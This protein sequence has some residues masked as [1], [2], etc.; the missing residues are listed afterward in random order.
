MSTMSS[1][2]PVPGQDLPEQNGGSRANHQG[3][4]PHRLARW[5]RGFERP[6]LARFL[7]CVRPY[8]RYVVGAALAGIG[9]FALPFAF[10]LAFKYVLDVL[11]VPQPRPGALDG[12]IDRWCTEV[13]SLLGLGLTPRGKLIALTV[14]MLGLYAIQSVASYY[15]NYWAGVAGNGLIF[16]LRCR[17]FAHLQRLP[18]SFFDRNPPGAVVSRMVNDVE[19]ARQFVGSTMTDVWMDGVALLLIGWFLFLLDARLAIISLAVAPLYVVMITYFSPRIRRA[20]R[21]IQETLEDISASLHERVVGAVTVKAFARESHEIALF[22][23]QA[24]RLYDY[25]IDKLRLTSGQQMLTELLTRV[26][27]S[28]VVWAAA[29][30]I[31]GHTMT[32]GTLVAFIGFLGYIYQPLEHFTQLSSVVSSALSAIERIF[33]LLDVAPDIRDHPLAR[34]LTVRRGALEFEDV[35]FAYPSRQ[36]HAERIV[37]GDISF[38][39]AGG[40]T[41]ALVGR[42]GAGKTTLAS[43]IPRFYDAT[44]GRVLIDGKDVRHLTLKSLRENIG[45]VTQ[46]TILFSA[47]VRDNLLYGNPRADEQ[48]LWDALA[49]A[50]LKSFVESLPRGL[51]TVIGERG[52][53]IS[54]GQRQRLALARAF[55]KNPAIL[56]LDE[57]TSAVDSESENLIHD[58]MHR[59]MDGRTT[60]LI[61][62]RLRSAIEADVIIVLDAGRI[63]E[64]GSHEELLSRRGLYAELYHEQIHGLAAIHP[65]EA[66]RATGGESFALN[67]PRRIDIHGTA[68]HSVSR[69][70][71]DA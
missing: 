9:K 22:R 30:M 71:K 1:T 43:L 4:R 7:A 64:T 58:A 51:D 15:R 25:N 49:Q 29:V 42:S 31:L 17:L 54:G 8:F 62:H 24:A 27:P 50:N 36:G 60:V 16:D 41:V 40:S 13:A 19:V 37:L 70:V 10:P 59:L 26:A 6:P 21:S 33:A 20:S 55:I 11:L 32:V 68:R 45:I 46:D 63:V 12:A 48:A 5:R 65:D 47:S 23:E 52:V 57:A 38:R 3:A 2:T 61:A 69:G 34:T 18:N 53:R 28:V 14:S 66:R 67:L 44:S 39:V 35:S 56:I